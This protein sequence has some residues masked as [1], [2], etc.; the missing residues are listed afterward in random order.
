[1]ASRLTLAALGVAAL[2]FAGSASAEDPVKIGMITTLS[3]PA[4]YLGEDARDGFLLAMDE[5]G[6]TLGGANVELLVEDDG[7]NPGNAQQIADR[8]LN[9]DDV[10]IVTGVI[11][12]NISPVVAPMTLEAGKFFISPNSAPSTFAGAECHEN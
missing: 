11:F 4:G 9:R 5:E 6:G 10:S 3:G 2:G 12:S 7:L 8:M 1:M